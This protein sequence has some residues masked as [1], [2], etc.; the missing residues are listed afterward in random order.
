MRWWGFECWG[1]VHSE[2]SGERKGSA[3]AEKRT[4][5]DKTTIK[6]SQKSFFLCRQTARE[7]C[8]TLSV[9]NERFGDVEFAASIVYLLTTTCACVYVSVFFYAAKQK[10]NLTCLFWSKRAESPLDEVRLQSSLVWRLTLRWTTEL[11]GTLL[12]NWVMFSRLSLYIK[13]PLFWLQECSLPVVLNQ[14]GGS[15]LMS[16]TL[17]RLQLWD[18]WGSNLSIAQPASSYS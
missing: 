17:H 16:L 9:P 7:T 10:N 15:W 6:K 14:I 13:T 12:T 18:I 11:R 8:E 5:K 4:C 1:C 3:T 2:T